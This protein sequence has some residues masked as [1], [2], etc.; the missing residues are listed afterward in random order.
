M[1]A[2]H[3]ATVKK[4]VLVGLGVLALIVIFAASCSSSGARCGDYDREE[5]YVYQ[6]GRGDYEKSGGQYRFVGAN[7]GDYGREIRYEYDPNDGDYDKRNGQYVYV[8]CD[9]GR[10]G[11][12]S[13][14]SSRSSGGGVWFFGGSSS[15]SGSSNRG[16][17]PGWGK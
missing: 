2:D 13:S 3:S 10:R 11:G 9:D 8:G 5:V 17:G 1:T 12:S 4:S 7:R 15:G 16:G 14:S 6:P